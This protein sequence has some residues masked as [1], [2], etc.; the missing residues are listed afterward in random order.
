MRKE[1]S[2][3]QNIFSMQVT[4]TP[5]TLPDEKIL[6]SP[7]ANPLRRPR[8]ASNKML[9]GE[10]LKRDRHFLFQAFVLHKQK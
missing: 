3:A 2:A 1:F 5:Q 7:L 6:N 8:I 10:L 9:P 4:V